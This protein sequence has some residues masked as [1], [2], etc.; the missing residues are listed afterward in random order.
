MEKI[1][2]KME[3]KVGY[4]VVRTNKGKLWSCMQTGPYALKYSVGKWKKPIIG[5]ILYFSELE[6]A[7]SFCGEY[8]WR[9]FRDGGEEEYMLEIY[10]SEIDN[11]VKAPYSLCGSNDYDAIFWTD[12][13][14]FLNSRNITIPSPKGTW[15]CDRIKLIEKIE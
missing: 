10:K 4:K 7:V 15:M 9:V 13:G 5:K 1:S 12:I 11:G 14:G 2:E 6:N 8:H 3:I